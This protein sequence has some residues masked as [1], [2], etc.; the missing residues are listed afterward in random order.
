VD[1]LERANLYRDAFVALRDLTA[2]TAGC[3]RCLRM[4]SSGPPCPVYT[5]AT[6]KIRAANTLWLEEQHASVG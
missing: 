5:E 6:T 4:T 3:T 1:D 2:H